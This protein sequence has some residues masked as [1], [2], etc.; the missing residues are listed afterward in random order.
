MNRSHIRKIILISSLALL[1]VLILANFNALMRYYPY[2]KAKTTLMLS[3]DRHDRLNSLIRVIEDPDFSFDT[4]WMA[5]QEA[6]K[7]LHSNN[8]PE[9]IIRLMTASLSI[10]TN[11]TH[12]PRMIQNAVDAGEK[13]GVHMRR[14]YD[15]SYSLRGATY[16]QLGQYSNA[17]ADLILVLNPDHSELNRFH[18]A[19]GWSA[20]ETSQWEMAIEHLTKQINRAPPHAYWHEMRGISHLHLDQDKMAASNFEQAITFKT[21]A[22]RAYF[23]LSTLYNIST[24]ESIQDHHRAL[25]VINKA[26]ATTTNPPLVLYK[27]KAEALA[28]FGR[29][30]ESAE[31]MQQAVNMVINDPYYTNYVEQFEAQIEEYK[32]KQRMQ[33][34]HDSTL[35]FTE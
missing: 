24:N 21:N 23:Y 34:T 32:K 16:F 20:Y 1:G 19:L 28:E 18:E 30:D 31:Y 15:L 14:L 6:N 5:V 9:I 25:D 4:R 35:L 26:F 2:F 12:H 22:Y 27:R 13:P 17:Y 3:T 11:T 7:F 29:F 8:D 10:I 33:D